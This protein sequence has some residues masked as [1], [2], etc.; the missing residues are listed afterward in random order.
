MEP[1][2]GGEQMGQGSWGYTWREWGTVWGRG[3]QALPRTVSRLPV[4]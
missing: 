4:N 1:G 2:V 3:G